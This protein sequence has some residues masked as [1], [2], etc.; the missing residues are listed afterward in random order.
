MN[1]K[2]VSV[3]NCLQIGLQGARRA[4]QFFA[5]VKKILH[6]R[7]LEKIKTYIFRCFFIFF[8]ASS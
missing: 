2:R 3:L 4:D 6:F 5:F 1:T 8:A 7:F